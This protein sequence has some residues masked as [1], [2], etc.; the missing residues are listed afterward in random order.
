M[1]FGWYPTLPPER[2]YLELRVGH[3]F[4][5]LKKVIW[6]AVMKTQKSLK[7]SINVMRR[8]SLRIYFSV[9]PVIGVWLRML[10]QIIHNKVGVIQCLA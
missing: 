2:S 10:Q 4:A 3:F 8:P 5:V 7:P 9:V 1:S 6:M